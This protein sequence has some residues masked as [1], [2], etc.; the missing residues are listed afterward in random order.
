MNQM[1]PKKH[2]KKRILIILGVLAVL[3]AALFL[4]AGNITIK[5]MSVTGNEFYTSEEIRDMLFD[6]PLKRNSIYCY[7]I[8]RAHV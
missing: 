5:E 4:V 6:T 2:R 8:G 1:K 3:L 7:Q